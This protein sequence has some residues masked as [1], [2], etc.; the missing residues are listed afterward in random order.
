MGSVGTISFQNESIRSRDIE[1]LIHLNQK[2]GLFSH[3]K[4]HQ[5]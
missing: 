1:R 5:F 4:P 2:W 3:G